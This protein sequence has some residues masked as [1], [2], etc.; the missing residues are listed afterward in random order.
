MTWDD[1]L[2]DLISKKWKIGQ[3]FTLE[4]I[5]QFENHFSKLYPKNNFV[6]DKLRQTLQHLR[7]KG[8]VEF[9]NKRGN[10]T[11]IK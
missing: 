5:Y 9:K 1:E 4:D 6:E 8:Y 10:Y 7:N 11:R 3:S 2:L